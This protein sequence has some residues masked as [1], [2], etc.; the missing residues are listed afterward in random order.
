VHGQISPGEF[1]PIAERSGLIV[2]LGEWVLAEACRNCRSW[3]S[4]SATRTGVAVNVSAAQFEQ[5][6]FSRRVAALLTKTGLSPSLL[7]IELTE[8]VLMRDLTRANEHLNKLRNL[9]VRVALD[10]FGTGYSSLSYLTTL[11]ADAIKLDRSFVQ[12]E[13]A[14][15][16]GILASLVQMA[17]GIGLRVVAEGVETRA[18]YQRLLSMDCDQLQGFYFSEPLPASAVPAYLESHAGGTGTSGDMALTQ[19]AP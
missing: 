7:T 19:L 3:R 5:P 4:S 11:P 1:I 9:G 8:T 14:N 17:H 18:Q 16:T 15:P 12:R 6:D 2:S 10:D 13:F